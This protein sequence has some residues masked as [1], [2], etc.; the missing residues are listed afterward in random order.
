MD[1]LP[2]IEI[3][4]IGVITT[5][6]GAG[7][8]EVERSVTKPLESALVS[9]SG[10]KSLNSIS[11]T[12]QSIVF[13]EMNYGASLDEAS[14]QMRDYIDRV[15][16]YLPDDADSPLIIKVDPSMLP[17]MFLT[18]DGQRTSEELYRYATDNVQPMLEQINGVA[19]VGISG[20]RDEAINIEIP[21]DR[22]EAYNLTITQVSQL[23][24]AQ[25]VDSSAGTITENEM[26]Y[27]I[28]TQ[29]SYQSLNDMLDT[30]IAYKTVTPTGRQIPEMRTIKLR[31]IAD[32]IDGYKPRTSIAYVNGTPAIMMS[33]TKQSDA[34]TVQVSDAIQA[35]IPRIN[36][37]LPN[38]VKLEI[39]SDNS[40]MI[41]SSIS[42]V[43]S[44]VW[45]G[46]VLAVII[47]L[48]FLRS[49][50]ATIII[51]LSIPFSVI[52]T[53]MLMYFFNL[54]L[55]LM[56]LAGL[57]LGIG[58]LVDNSIVILENIFR[59]TEKGS[60]PTVAAML[61]SSEMIG[62]ITGSTLT[63]VCVF[64]P[65]IMLQSELGMYG[66]VFQ[67]LAFTVVFSLMCSLG[68]AIFLVPVLSSHY[69]VIKD[70]NKP[71]P[72]F[73]E[74]INQ[75]L[76][77]FFEAMDRGYGNLVR[78]ILKHKAIFISII[79]V[80][81]AGSLYL[82]ISGTIPFELFPDQSSDSVSITATLP[83]GTSLDV[84]EQTLI[85]LNNI[86]QKEITGL[87]ESNFRTG[88]GLL[89][90]G[91][92]SGTLQLELYD[93]DERKGHPE[94]MTS[95]EVEAKLR[96]YFASFP[97][98]TLA[99]QSGGMSG[100]GSS[101]AIDVTIKS[102]DLNAART[103][104]NEIVELFRT[105]GQDYVLDASSTLQDG[106]PQVNIIVDRDRMQQFGLNIAT[107]GAEI[108]GNITGITVGR[109]TKSGTDIDIIVQL[110]E[111]DREQLADLSNIFV[112]SAAGMRIPLSS[113]ARYEETTSPVSINREDQ[114][115]T[116]HVTATPVTGVAVA[117]AESFVEKLIAENIPYNESVQISYGNGQWALIVQYLGVFFQIIA[118]AVLLVFAVMAAQFESFKDPFIIIFCIP[119]SFIGIIL[120]YLMTGEILSLMTAVGFL[121]LV[122]VIV[123]NGIV[124]VDYTNLLRK[125]GESLEDACAHAAANRLRP[126][127]MSVLTTVLGLVP[128]AFFGGDGAE[129]TGPMGKTVL[130]GLSWGT[131]MTLFMVPCI[132]YIFN[133]GNEKKKVLAMATAQQRFEAEFRGEL[134]EAGAG[135]LTANHGNHANDKT[136]GEYEG[137][138][139]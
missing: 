66:Q 14:N 3:P 92:N 135:R 118:L 7:P 65:M 27:T 45:Q 138:T 55:N 129:M 42:N 52:V 115:R 38:D 85:Q 127:L 131:L 34:N 122:G 22:L 29:G 58:M 10:I 76:G 26:D 18:L 74:P 5:Y 80:L 79:A 19:S 133:K 121:I 137:E 28:Q 60:R 77:G 94:Y 31:D 62:A 132:Y 100:L 36:N 13:L 37:A 50:K 53:L 21:R 11:S 119:L 46:A 102:E 104:A 54:T 93:S 69:L 103:T 113:F 124:L 68:T 2:N 105:K 47:L 63:T 81:F 130:G 6:S 51:G 33:V 101:G 75:A 16:A 44:S 67:G 108:R 4:Y 48:V 114:A 41:R 61:G 43:I 56:T 96:P 125:R 110:A 17:V 70:I 82:V 83:Q 134:A 40:N 71:K 123:N 136:V 59:Y 73:L 25:N 39:V 32:V 91:T 86:A 24:A 107:V 1:L 49:W 90:S 8:E 57:A 117:D 111:K 23:I 126:I 9:V 72:G 15:R 109:Y 116:I 78:R 95:T 89:S 87:K 84:T 128:M 20:G 98:V 99:F 88:G 106:L 120:M 12:G 64:L 35:Q 97:G 30:V 139:L 112:T